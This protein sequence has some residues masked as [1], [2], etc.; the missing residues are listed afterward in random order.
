M[1]ILEYV[2]IVTEDFFYRPFSLLLRIWSIHSSLVK[3][4]DGIKGGRGGYR[5]TSQ[6][7]ESFYQGMQE[8]LTISMYFISILIPGITFYH[9]AA[10]LKA[11]CCYLIN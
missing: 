4:W 2:D 9:L 5:Y 7:G 6:L 1:D 8:T 11:C 3:D 10:W